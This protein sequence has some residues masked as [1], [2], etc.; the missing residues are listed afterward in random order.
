MGPHGRTA[1]CNVR[2]L[3]SQEAPT[4]VEHGILVYK[5]YPKKHKGG[6]WVWG[7]T[8]LYRAVY[9]TLSDILMDSIG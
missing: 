6:A 7:A 3:G 4:D 9:M 1:S 8:L 2:F 5:Q